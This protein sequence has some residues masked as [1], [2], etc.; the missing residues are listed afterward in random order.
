M[1]ANELIDLLE[2]RGLLD[3]EI[4]EALRDQMRQSGARVTPEAMVKLLVDNNH[5][6]RFQATQ[7][8]GE[9]RSSQYG[10]ATEEAPAGEDAGSLETLDLAPDG[11]DAERATV[12]EAI[13]V[14]DDAVLEAEPVEAEPVTA[15]AIPVDDE[16]A[17]AGEPDA[18]GRAG[19]S[20]V[21]KPQKR[22]QHDWGSFAIIGVA[23]AIILLLLFGGGLYFILRKGDSAAYISRANEL[24]DAQNFGSAEKAYEDFLDRFGDADEHSSIARTRRGMSRILQA[25]DS[26]TDPTR[27]LIVLQEVLPTIEDEAGMEQ[28][29]A[30]L[31]G[32]LVDVAEQIAAAADEAEETEEKKRLLAALDQ[33]IEFILDAKY[34]PSTIRKTLATRIQ[35]VQESR[36][37]VQR[38][39]NRNLRL[40]E[41]LVAMRAALDAEETKTAYEQRLTLLREYPELQDSEALDALIREASQI[42][43]TLVQPAETIPTTRQ[44]AEPSEAVR[45]IVLANRVGREIPSMRGK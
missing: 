35:S 16:A 2:R 5:L 37:R 19:G 42:Q 29:R 7:L 44:S 40:S 45:S 15:D 39:I 36:A 28:E 26:I 3:Q 8:I 10:E 43:K 9:L 14:D 12:A 1:L 20:R 13:P 21:R 4:I 23:A 22:E 25:K 34:V 41:T 17:A 38:A 18:P 30:N 32:F 11:D 27:P 6:T 33:Q 31:A 24:Y